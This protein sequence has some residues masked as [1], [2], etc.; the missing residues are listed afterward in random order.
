MEKGHYPDYAIKT[1]EEISER[2]EREFQRVW[3]AL[4][5]SFERDEVMHHLFTAKHKI[6]LIIKGNEE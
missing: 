2:L 3:G 6:N 4:S 1:L 5:P